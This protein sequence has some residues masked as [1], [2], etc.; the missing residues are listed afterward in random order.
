MVRDLRAAGMRV[1]IDSFDP[2]EI[3]TAVAAGAEMVLSV[4]RS[5]LEVGRELRGTGAAA[6]VIPDLGEGLDTLEPSIEAL[7][8]L[9]R[10]L[11]ASTRSSSRS[12]SASW[13]RSSGTPRC[14]DAIRTRGR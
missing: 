10:A 4:N 13:P 7:E 9:G 12:G 1:S 6:V 14:G 2:D 11:P 3:R 8:R 5:N